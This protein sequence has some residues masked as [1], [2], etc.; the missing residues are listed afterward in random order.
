MKV[1]E[2]FE[3]RDNGTNKCSVSL[4]AVDG[5]GIILRASLW[6]P[7]NGWRQGNIAPLIS[8]LWY[9]GA[10]QG[11]LIT[12]MSRHNDHRDIAGILQPLCRHI[13]GTLCPRLVC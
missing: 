11:T 4:H 1:F 6:R 5:Q 12:A 3:S 2:H 9:R 10:H 13:S 7:V 8:S